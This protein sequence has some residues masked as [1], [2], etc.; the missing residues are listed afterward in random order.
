MQ[1]KFYKTASE[2]NRV[3]KTLTDETDLIGNFKGKVDLQNPVITVTSNLQAFNYC[4]IPDLNRYYFIEKIELTSKDI[5]T[6][7][8]HIDVLMSYS[9]AI[10]QLQAVVSSSASNPYYSGYING[11]DVRTEYTTLQFE[12]NFNENG[13]I[14][15]VALYGANRGDE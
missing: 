15:L 9:T 11:V 4:Y 3:D 14:I 8:L 2:N 10:K 7:T 12:N 6:L 5:F 13:E 1:I